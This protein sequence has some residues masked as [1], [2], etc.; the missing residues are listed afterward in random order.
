MSRRY[1][2]YLAHV[3]II[4]LPFPRSFPSILKLQTQPLRFLTPYLLP[5]PSSKGKKI[6]AKVASFDELRKSYLK[7]SLVLHPDRN[8]GVADAT[9]AFQGWSRQNCFLVF[10][11]FMRNQLIPHSLALV[12]AFESVSAPDWTAN[13]EEGS[14]GHAKLARGNSG[15]FR[16]KVYC[17]RCKEPWGAS[18]L[19]GN[20]DYY[21]NFLM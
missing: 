6:D 20:P 8:R 14:G 15:C 1:N 4:H 13:K 5:T 10:S 2:F 18:K 3:R 21:Y 16:T 11:I 17:P 9:K 12:K 7:L 19:E